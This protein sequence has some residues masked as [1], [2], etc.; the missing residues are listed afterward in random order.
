MK[1]T[2]DHTGTET[3]RFTPEIEL[4]NEAMRTPSDISEALK[5]AAKLVD[6]GSDFGTIRDNNGNTVG[7]WAY[8]GQF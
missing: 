3:T 2:P 4:G 5:W 1:Q 7:E 6:D 8:R